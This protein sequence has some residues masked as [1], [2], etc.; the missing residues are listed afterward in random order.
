VREAPT[1]LSA[2]VIPPIYLDRFISDGAP[3]ALFIE[4][5]DTKGKYQEERLKAQIDCMGHT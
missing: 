3:R 1:R 5:L 4:A 2:L